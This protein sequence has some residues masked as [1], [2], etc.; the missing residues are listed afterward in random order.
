[1]NKNISRLTRKNERKNK[2]QRTNLILFGAKH[3]YHQAKSSED[4]FYFHPFDRKKKSFVRSA[5][6]RRD[7]NFFDIDII[8]VEIQTPIEMKQD[9]SRKYY[10]NRFALSHQSPQKAIDPNSQ[11]KE[12]INNDDN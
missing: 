12:A 10:R 2:K 3:L 11:E 4:V 8:Q 1:M 7:Y 5:E 9:H 6:I